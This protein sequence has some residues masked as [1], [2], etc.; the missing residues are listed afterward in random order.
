MPPESLVRDTSAITGAGYTKIS[1]ASGV[2]VAALA[3]ECCHK[4]ILDAGL[5]RQDIDGIISYSVGDSVPVRDVATALGLPSLQW[6]NDTHGGGPESCGIIAQAALAIAGGLCKHVLCFRA[7]NGRSG[8]R[9]GQL[10]SHP[11]SATGYGGDLQ[12]MAPFGYA[13][14]PHRNAM[15]MRRHM[16]LYGTAAEQFGA[17]AVTLRANAVHNERAIMRAPITLD[18]YLASRFIAEPLRLL[19][20]CQETDAGCAL[21]VSRADLARS[22]PHRPAH[23]MSFAYG[24]GPGPSVHRDKDPDFTTL[25]PRYIAQ[26]LFDR[27]GVSVA[28]V[29]VAE[30]YDAFTITVICQLE[31]F[32]FCNKGEGG[33]FVQAGHIALNGRIPVGTHGGLL[34]EGYMHGFNNIAEAVSQIRGDA[35]AR[36]VKDAEIVLCSGFGGNVGSALLL[37]R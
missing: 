14:P 31:D 6:A 28:D 16:A 20:C 32:G 9:M 17:V 25:F 7:L 23:V 30:I 29:D 24:G 10:G 36:Q 19:D 21:I 1:R 3:L 26:G 15:A 33:P 18:D 27:A 12:F 34:S 37:R 22:M 35:G 5:A 4:A 2:S 13:G 11:T 8:A